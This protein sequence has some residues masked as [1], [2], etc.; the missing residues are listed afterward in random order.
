MGG[1]INKY[2][3]IYSTDISVLTLMN[4]KAKVSEKGLNEKQLP[5]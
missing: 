1:N 2:V 5:F 3:F 4:S